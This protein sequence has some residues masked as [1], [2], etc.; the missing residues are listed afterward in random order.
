M[1][2][3]GHTGFLN[4]NKPLRWTSH[5]AVA[6]VRHR[7]RTLT[8]CKKVGHAGTLDPLASGVLVLCLG[9]ATRLSSYVMH[10]DKHYQAEITL[11]KTTASYDAEGEV[12]TV[13]DTS[14]ITL[15]AIQDVLRQFIGDIQQV[16]PMY[17]AV[18]VGGQKLYQLARQGKSVK[19]QA[20]QAHIHAIE[21]LSWS[22]P[23]I[24]LDV[25]CSSGTY[26][27]SLAHDIGRALHAGAYLS[28]LRRV[29]SG[30]F[31]IGDSIT[32]DKITDG[33]E[34][35]K[36]IIPP[37]AA[38]KHQPGLTL[39]ASEIQ[40]IQKGQFIRR[41]TDLSADQVFAFTSDKQLV[42]ILKPQGQLWKPHKVFWD[43]P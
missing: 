38:L 8:G 12:I 31:K 37:H 6:R 11:G 3:A 35:L 19:R 43:Q 2:E 29:A 10:T 39:N 32:L 7:Y 15:S 28:A 42:A 36:H 22:S 16:P 41:R 34:W 18:K 4:L 25:R 40:R 30:H 21:I 9:K 5:D 33:D 1:A 27:R 23:V 26:M 14:H 17:S 24:E 13:S 20:R